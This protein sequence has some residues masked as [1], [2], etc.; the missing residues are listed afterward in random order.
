[1]E[2]HY[3][4]YKTIDQNPLDESTLRK[5]VSESG[6][7]MIG[8]DFD[9]DDGMII[10]DSPITKI[11]RNALLGQTTLK[12]IYLPDTVKVIDAFAFACCYNLDYIQMPS[13]ESIEDF[14][15][16]DCNSLL[17]ITI[18]QNVKKLGTNAFSGC[19]D[20][21]SIYINNTCLSYK[22]IKKGFGALY[23]GKCI[24][25][26]K[27]N[28]NLDNKAVSKLFNDAVVFRF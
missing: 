5:F 28:Q 15:F 12:E 2:L 21:H 14:A 24:F 13:V 18:R 6:H 20:R 23:H 3:I 22:D 17:D 16:L 7:Q 19:P 9:E 26:N 1:M 25:I 11:E 8:H 10:F 27:N 4:H